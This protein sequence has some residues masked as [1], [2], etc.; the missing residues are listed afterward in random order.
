[1]TV[2]G[3][4]LYINT[5]AFQKYIFTYIHKQTQCHGLSLFS[6]LLF[7]EF[8]VQPGEAEAVYKLS[9]KK[10]WRLG[11]SSSLWLDASQAAVC[12]H[13][14]CYQGNMCA[15]PVTGGVYDGTCL[16][17]MHIQH[18]SQCP[19][20]G[21]EALFGCGVLAAPGLE[22]PGWSR[23][24][25]CSPQCPPPFLRSS[26]GSRCSALSLTAPHSLKWK[27]GLFECSQVWHILSV[28]NPDGTWWDVT[29]FKGAVICPEVGS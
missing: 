1:M 7:L 6:F 4:T 28:L 12:W 5:L 14:P 27:W 3:L 24:A 25:R 17:L 23:G 16:C 8:T 18:I 21:A 9:E 29:N 20:A 19:G 22:G 10:K 11:S 2:F 26:L 13:C 15:R